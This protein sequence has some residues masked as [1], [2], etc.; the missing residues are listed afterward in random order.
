MKICP[1]G[2]ELFHTDRHTDMTKLI[3]AFRSYARRRLKCLDNTQ[4]TKV[5]S[6]LTENAKHPFLNLIALMG[7]QK[8]YHFSFVQYCNIC[9]PSLMFIQPED[10]FLKS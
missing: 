8:N 2:A 9:V 10:G 7:I 6:Y 1:V 4:N 5:C 3:V